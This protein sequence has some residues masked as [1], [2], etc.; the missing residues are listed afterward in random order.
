MDSK[1]SRVHLAN[2]ADTVLTETPGKQVLTAV[3][4][5]EVLT[6]SEE[7]PAQRDCLDQLVT[8]EH[9]EAE[10]ALEHLVLEE[11]QESQEETLYPGLMG[12]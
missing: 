4:E 8:L 9:Q 12:C 6:E 1:A 7:C 2:Q 5:L 3:T 11:H 10:D